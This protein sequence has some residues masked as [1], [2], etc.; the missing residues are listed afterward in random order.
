MNGTSVHE[1]AVFPVPTAVGSYIDNTGT[2]KSRHAEVPFVAVAEGM[3]EARLLYR[4][5]LAF[6]GCC[7]TSKPAAEREAKM[8]KM[9]LSGFARAWLALVSRKAIAWLLATFVRP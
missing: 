1:T 2:H 9:T 5:C 8:K 4:S 7:G 3:R 6:D